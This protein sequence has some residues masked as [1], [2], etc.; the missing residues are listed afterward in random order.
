MVHVPP[1]STPTSDADLAG[2]SG[3]NVPES[4]GVAQFVQ[5]EMSAKFHGIATVTSMAEALQTASGAGSV[6]P[7]KLHPPR[8]IFR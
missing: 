4:W 5:K 1:L 8:V 3:V 7:R 2:S 6:A